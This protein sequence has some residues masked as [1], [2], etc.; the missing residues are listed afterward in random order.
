MTD[1]PFTTAERA[2]LGTLGF[3]VTGASVAHFN[4]GFA[5]G[6]N[7]RGGQSM[8]AQFGLFALQPLIGPET[9]AAKC[10]RFVSSRARAR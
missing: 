5:P 2:A 1:T 10:S 8:V 6:S 3:T 4:N 7:W 9:G